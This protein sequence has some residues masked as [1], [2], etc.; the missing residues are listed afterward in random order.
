MGPVSIFFNLNPGL[1]HCL[2]LQPDAQKVKG[3]NKTGGYRGVA[4]LTSPAVR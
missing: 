1:T 2:T 4:Q 3:L